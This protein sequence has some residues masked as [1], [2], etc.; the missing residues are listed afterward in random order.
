MELFLDAEDRRIPARGAV[1]EAHA[2]EQFFPED[3]NVSTSDRVSAA[4]VGILSVCLLIVILAALGG[5]GDILYPALILS[6]VL[7][8]LLILLNRH[9]YGFFLEERGFGFTLLAIPMHF[10]YF[11][12]SGASY[13]ACWLKKKMSK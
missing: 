4:L 9:L 6:A 8:I 13:G 2:G 12:Y 11:F 1:V 10:L 7:V 5:G 3:L